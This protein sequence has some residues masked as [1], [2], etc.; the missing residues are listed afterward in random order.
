MKVELKDK[1]KYTNI[2][3]A[4]IL[5]GCYIPG[6]E[7]T[8]NTYSFTHGDFEKTVL[9]VGAAATIF[10]TGYRDGDAVYYSIYKFTIAE[11]Q[12]IKLDLKQVTEDQ[13]KELLPKEL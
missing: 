2:Y 4:L 10:F 1:G 6:Y 12:Q 11:N 3:V 9:P 13:L 8:D 5:E 7:K